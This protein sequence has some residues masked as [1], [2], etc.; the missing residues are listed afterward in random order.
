MNGEAA[1]TGPPV[2]FWVHP[3]E[4]GLVGGPL[5]LE[6][7]RPVEPQLSA[8]VVTR[9]F[10]GRVDAV[11]PCSING[12]IEGSS[13]AAFLTALIFSKI[14]FRSVLRYRSLAD[15]SGWVL[16]IRFCFFQSEIS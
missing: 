5:A 13:L 6:I 1:F 10:D 4:A 12:L 16:V 15:R 7:V 3:L 9:L 8:E 11:L 14:G 2:K